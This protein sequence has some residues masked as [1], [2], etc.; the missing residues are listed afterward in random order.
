MEVFILIFIFVIGT[1]L[2]SFYN[3]VGYRLPKGQSIV[4]PPSHCPNCN[5]RL[6]ASELIPIISF[7]FLKG[8]CK[9]CRQKI[10]AFYPVFEF[11]T[12]LLFVISYIIFGP[13]KE[14]L[15]AITFVSLLIIIV[16]SDYEFMIIEDSVLIFFSILLFAEIW[17]VNGLTK[18][19]YSLLNG[20]LAFFTMW[21]LKKFGDFLFKKESMGG[22]DIK[23]LFIFGMVLSYPIAILSI[24]LGSLIGLPISLIIMAKK[25]AHI[26]P[27]GPFLALG[28]IILFFTQIDIQTIVDFYH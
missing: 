12:G 8:K 27:F 10:S 4:F 2:G 28:A 22:G 25:K 1:L 9:H 7:I 21:A 20:I 23:L 11:L 13:T 17:W 18:A 5:H 6:G 26:I 16:V 3:V 15:L 24:F 19:L 14:F